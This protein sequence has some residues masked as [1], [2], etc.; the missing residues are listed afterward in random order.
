[1][2]V[3]PVGHQARHAEVPRRE[4]VLHARAFLPEAS[5]QRARHDDASVDGRDDVDPQVPAGPRLERDRVPHCAAVDLA[6]LGEVHL[7]VDTV[8]R[9][10]Q[11]ELMVL[12]LVRG[13][14]RLRERSRMQRVA[15]SEVVVLHLEDVREVAAEVQRQL[16]LHRV[17]ALVLDHDVVLHALPDEPVAA[18]RDHVV[19]EAGRW[20]P[21]VE[22]GREVLDLLRREQQGTLAVDREAQTRQEA[23]VRREEAV[24][25]RDEIAELVADAERRAVENRERHAW[26]ILRRRAGFAPLRTVRAP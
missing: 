26:P 7:R 22:A 19:L 10:L 18:D 6:G 12:G 11:E 4:R 17:H 14:D 13:L 5:L 3:V 16:E 24:R 8:V 20:V 2:D 9:A 23:R 15:E 1:V 25:R 21:Q